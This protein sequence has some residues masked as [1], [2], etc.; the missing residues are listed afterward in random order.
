MRNSHI[1]LISVLFFSTYVWWKKDSAPV[2]TPHPAPMRASQKTPSPPTQASTPAPAVAALGEPASG[3]ERPARSVH[4]KVVDEWVIGYGDILLGKP[5]AEDFP[6]D[7]FANVPTW[8][9][10]PKGKIPYSIH[11]DLPNPERVMRVVEYFNS[12]TNLK[13]VPYEGG[14]DSIVFAPFKGHCLSYLG[15]IGGH[16]P[17]FLDDR[18][19]DSEITHEI[20]HAVGFVHEHSRPDRDRFVKVNWDNILD[21]KRDQFETVPEELAKIV[22]NRPFDFKSAMIYQSSAFAKDR[23]S[24]TL[25]SLREEKIEPPE[26]GLSSEDI[27]RVNQLYP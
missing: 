24:W 16:Q 1:V 26:N 27:A 9:K 12:N 23:G 7:G 8:Q 20:M 4:Y 25:Q 2:S 21:E 15:R 3:E 19:S 18:C 10:W 22:M 13:L 6:S 11:V 5:S 14:E 17:V